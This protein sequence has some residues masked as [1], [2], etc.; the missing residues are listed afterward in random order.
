MRVRKCYKHNKQNQVVIIKQFH[1][2]K[3]QEVQEKIPKSQK[4]TSRTVMQHKYIIQHKYI[5][6][7]YSPCTFTIADGVIGSVV[8]AEDPEKVI[9]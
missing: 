5:K 3:L 7:F 9:K 1:V 4:P 6:I 8:I 2:N